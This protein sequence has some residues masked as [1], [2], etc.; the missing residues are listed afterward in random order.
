MEPATVIAGLYG[1]TG[2]VL[3]AAFMVMLIAWFES[4]AGLK[5][6]HAEG[7]QAG[8]RR[9]LEIADPELLEW[10]DAKTEFQN[11]PVICP[12]RK[13]KRKTEGGR[14]PPP[15]PPRREDW[16][17]IRKSVMTD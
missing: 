13:V 5:D 17:D 15:A 3:G 6:K 7:W 10:L 9:A 8:W 4:H 1:L 16:N 14:T 2:F 11:M 12:A